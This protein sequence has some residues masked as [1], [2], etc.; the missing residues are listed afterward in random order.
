[1]SV[2]NVDKEGRW[3]NVTIGFRVSEEEN[4]RVNQLVGLSGMTKQAFILSKLEDRQINVLATIRVQ[5]AFAV[6]ARRVADE[7]ERLS[8]GEQ[9]NARQLEISEAILDILNQMAAG[10]MKLGDE[11]DEASFEEMELADLKATMAP[12]ERLV[13][14]KPDE[15]KPVVV[16]ERPMPQKK[17]RKGVKAKG[18]FKKD[19]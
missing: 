4:E 19:S 13:P 1:M 9:P 6:Q 3:R 11:H 8:A 16:S 12:D 10:G 14:L 17:A 2:K 18:L 15:V 7:L 5:K